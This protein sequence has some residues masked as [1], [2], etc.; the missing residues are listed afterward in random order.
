MSHGLRVSRNQW[1]E[2]VRQSAT[3]I[4]RAGASRR[5]KR[6][7]RPHPP[8]KSRIRGFAACRSWLRAMAYS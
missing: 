1:I 3:V 8:P 7:T 5:K 6:D 2:S 4:R